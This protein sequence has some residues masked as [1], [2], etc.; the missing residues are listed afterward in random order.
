MGIRISLMRLI[1]AAVIVGAGIY[2]ARHDGNSRPPAAL[3]PESVRILVA[4]APLPTGTLIQTSHLNWADWPKTEL[5]PGAFQSIDALLGS[6]AGQQRLVRRAFGA[7][8]PIVSGKVSE[9][10]RT[11][12]PK[13]VGPGMRLVSILIDPTSGVSR[14][15]TPG[16]WVDI[17][18]TREQDGGLT[19]SVIVENIEV[20]AIDQRSPAA[21]ATPQHS[22]TFTV[23]VEINQAQ[24]LALAGQVGRLSIV[25]RGSSQLPN[26]EFIDPMYDDRSENPFPPIDRSEMPFPPVIRRS[27]NRFE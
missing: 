4:R 9:L 24:K 2:V 10:S 22:R 1:A 16:D 19:H 25:L 26:R 23:A 21:G 14:F 15:V 8:E 13:E 7:G 27:P 5:P 12:R 17:L 6:D 20:V 11:P 18:L 3:G